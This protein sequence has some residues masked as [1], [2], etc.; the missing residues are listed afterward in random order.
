MSMHGIQWMPRQTLIPCPPGAH[1]VGR[2]RVYNHL[3]ESN[4]IAGR[5][6]GELHEYL[7]GRNPTCSWRNAP[8]HAMALLD[9][10]QPRHEI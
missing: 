3:F 10:E 1:W 8:C 9:A 4:E 2:P 6:T 7:A 5:K